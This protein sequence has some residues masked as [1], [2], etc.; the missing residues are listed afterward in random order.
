[1][2]DNIKDNFDKIFEQLGD[3]KHKLDLVYTMGQPVNSLDPPD[4]KPE[5]D[6]D[7]WMELAEEY[8]GIDEVNDEGTVIGMAKV[9]G[10]PIPSSDTPWCAIFVNFVLT[11]ANLPITGSMRARDF[12]NYGEPCEEKRGAIVVY[13]SHVGF[14][15]EPG[16][17]LGGNQSDGVNIGE[18]RWYGKPIA[19]R[20][21]VLA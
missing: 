4:P 15:S 16:K 8:V 21:P 18:Q 3:I 5:L 2:S 20:W 9:A 13:R 11:K 10:T 14:V 6:P 1:M 19:Y 7:M 12:E 17:V